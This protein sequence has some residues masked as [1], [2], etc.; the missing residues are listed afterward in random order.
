MNSLEYAEQLNKIFEIE[1][2]PEYFNFIPFKT[3]TSGFSIKKEY[4]SNIPF[5]PSVTKGGKDN[6]VALLRVILDLHKERN[7]TDK[8]P[9]LF[10]IGMH[11]IY[12]Y[13]YYGYNYDNDDC[14]TKES[15]EKMKNMPTPISGF[16]T[17][18]YF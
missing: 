7:I 18:K 13:K 10:E 15:L 17:D 8:I 14:P 3:G 1:N 5:K 4:P 6:N 2:H 16:L 12:E 9:L 11:S